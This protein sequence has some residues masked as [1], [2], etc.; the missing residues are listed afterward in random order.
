MEI[1]LNYCTGKDTIGDTKAKK[2]VALQPQKETRIK[3]KEE[4]IVL[5][6]HQMMIHHDSSDDDASDEG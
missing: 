4:K 2:D 1:M 3:G 6:V 5:M